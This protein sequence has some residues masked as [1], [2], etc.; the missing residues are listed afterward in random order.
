MA[1]VEASPC[2]GRFFSMLSAAAAASTRHGLNL[3]AA[4]PPQRLP[5]AAALRRRTSSPHGAPAERRGR[6]GDGAGLV[7]QGN[8]RAAG[9]CE[10]LRLA[11]HPWPQAAALAAAAAEVSGR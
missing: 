6:G 11:G 3:T 8:L 9:A 5:G 7:I 1:R 10:L 4:A 2:G